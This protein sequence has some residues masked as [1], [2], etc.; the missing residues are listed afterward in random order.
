MAPRALDQRLGEH[1]GEGQLVIGGEALLPALELRPLG[2]RP[3]RTRAAAMPYQFMRQRGGGRAIAVAMEWRRSSIEACVSRL[4][5]ALAGGSD[6]LAGS[7]LPAVDDF[8]LLPNFVSIS[9]LTDCAIA[10]RS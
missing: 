4:S 5:L 9:D 7:L 2:A 8:F 1:V 10:A 3:C 6:I